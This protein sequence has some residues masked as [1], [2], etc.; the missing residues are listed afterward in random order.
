MEG[1]RAGLRWLARPARARFVALLLSSLFLSASAP[2]SGEPGLLVTP[3][4]LVFEGKT[5]SATLTLLNTGTE[6]ATY[7]ILFIQ[8]EMMADGRIVEVARASGG[9]YADSLI[10]FSPRQVT[11]RPGAPQTVRLQMRKPAGLADGEY[12]SHLLFR[13]L[14]GANPI[15]SDDTGAQQAVSIQLTP[16][17][18]L[19]VPVIVRQGEMQ[20]TVG[21]PILHLRAP[22]P[23]TESILRVYLSRS[24]NRSV[25]GNLTVTYTDPG[26][27]SWPAGRVN[28]VAVYVPGELR[29]MDIPLTIPAG[30]SRKG[31]RLTVA[32]TGAGGTDEPLGEAAI[33]IR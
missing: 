13:A 18:G 4:R 2:A 28:G 16:V 27:A 31:G 33:Q 20:A 26:G 6:P 19:A 25:F 22:L 29:S 8:M 9:A 23:G 11:L 10:R 1:R 30:L 3:T 21:I 14:P 32:W 17:Y 12:R 15:D 7:R 5:R 24:G